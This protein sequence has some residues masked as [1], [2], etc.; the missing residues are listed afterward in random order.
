MLSNHV[1]YF[2]QSWASLVL[3]VC[4]TF[5]NRVHLW[6]Y[7]VYHRLRHLDVTSMPVYPTVCTVLSHRGH[8]CIGLF[9]PLG[10]TRYTPWLY[11]ATLL[12]C[13]MHLS[14]SGRVH[15]L[16]Q[17][18][19]LRRSVQRYMY[20]SRYAKC[21]HFNLTLSNGIPHFIKQRTPLGCTMYI[22]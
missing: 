10:Y 5:F 18:C 17:W 19:P 20:T 6:V 16:S 11:I 7:P 9:T 21:A 1:H 13:T 4:T 2:I 22:A 12:C 14:W 15:H 8:N 3:T